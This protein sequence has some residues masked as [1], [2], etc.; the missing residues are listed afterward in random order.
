MPSRC[1]VPRSCV[2]IAGSLAPV[3]EIGSIGRVVRIALK[4][5]ARSGLWQEFV[6]YGLVF[7]RASV[8]IDDGRE[9]AECCQHNVSCWN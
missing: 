9:G 6:V 7:G 5:V 1:R 8:S 2:Q 4:S 3:E